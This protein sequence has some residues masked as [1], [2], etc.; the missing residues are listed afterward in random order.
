LAVSFG[1]D[2]A[3]F[4]F[5]ENTMKN[6]LLLAALLMLFGQSSYAEEITFNFEGVVAYYIGTPSAL[7]TWIPVDQP[8]TGSFTFDT[9]TPGIED[10]FYL[11]DVSYLNALSHFT[12]DFGAYYLTLDNGHILVRDDWLAS[13]ESVPYDYYSVSRSNASWINPP[14]NVD[15]NIVLPN[16][17]SSTIDS[18]WHFSLMRVQVQDYLANLLSSTALPLIPPDISVASSTHFVLEFQ[19]D[20]CTGSND[21]HGYITSLVV[22]ETDGDGVRDSIDNCPT[23]PNPD[24]ANADGADD[25]GDA[26]DDDDDN[27]MICD[28]ASGVTGVCAAGPDNCR[29]IP[30]N[31][32]DDGDGDG[33]GDACDNCRSISNPGQ[34]LAIDSTD[35]G[36]ACV[37]TVC[38]PAI[39]YNP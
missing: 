17:V 4:A 14:A 15:T 29:T 8:F 33:S 16:Y 37:T 31:N 25:G 24:Q 28:G 27:D 38:G 26:C 35:C 12:V 32:Q 13:P 9:T 34:E 6:K 1:T 30:N 19:L 22:E 10:D 21:M 11:N 5:K 23:V 2:R 18:G 20:C 3:E 36:A 7:P 39:C